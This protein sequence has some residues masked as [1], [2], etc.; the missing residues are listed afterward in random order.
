MKPSHFISRSGDRFPCE[1]HSNIEEPSRGK[2]PLPADGYPY[3]VEFVHTAP[4]VFTSGDADADHIHNIMALVYHEDPETIDLLKRG[5]RD[6]PSRFAPFMLA[7]I[8]Y[9]TNDVAAYC[10]AKGLSDIFSYPLSMDRMVDVVTL[11][12]VRKECSIGADVVTK[13][14]EK[15]L[16]DPNLPYA[17]ALETSLPVMIAD[18]ELATIVAEVLSEFPDKVAEYRAGRKNIASMFIG[19]VMRKKKGM[20][21]KA[22]SAAI[23]A[24]LNS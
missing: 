5:C 14:V 7:A 12:S 24:A 17:D 23:E 9:V 21:P 8:N 20:D 1:T 19:S 2:L 4:P 10:N 13:V 3:R 11:M 16:A 15:L 22:V 6:N 18:S